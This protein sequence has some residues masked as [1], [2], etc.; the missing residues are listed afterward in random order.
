M[1]PE[2]QQQYL[3]WQKTFYEQ[4]ATSLFNK[5][6]K[7]KSDP[8]REKYRI[9]NEKVSKY[10]GNPVSAILTGIT[11]KEPF[12]S[13][14][15]VYEA[16]VPEGKT[17]I[18]DIMDCPGLAED[19][20]AERKKRYM[21]FFGTRPGTVTRALT[22]GRSMCASL[23][24]IWGHHVKHAGK[25]FMAELVPCRSQEGYVYFLIKNAKIV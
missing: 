3:E 1:T 14:V 19:T 5:A 10:I 24:T 12:N 15:M 4:K 20:N 9:A 25:H 22:D 6:P 8:K 16:F 7:P 2:E 21:D 18:Y 13:C 17:V 11:F 23:G